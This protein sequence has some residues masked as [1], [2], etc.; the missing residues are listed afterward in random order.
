MPLSQTMA[1]LEHGIADGLHLGA[2]VY[3]SLAGTAVADASIGEA[4]VGV[5][6]TPDTIVQWRSSGKPVGAVAIAQLWERG[7]LDLD[8]PVWRFIPEFRAHGKGAVTLR[9]L[10]THTAGL[11]L[12]ATGWTTSSWDEI[13][14]GICA[15]HL[16]AGWVPGLTAGYHAASSWYLLAEI[17]QRIDGRPYSRYVREAIFE[18]L[19]LHDSWIDIPLERLDAYGDRLSEMYNTEDRQ[20]P[21]MG[22]DPMS[23]GHL[24]LPTP[25]G[26]SRPISALQDPARGL[27]TYQ[28][29]GSAR[30][31]TRE[32]GRFYEML[33]ARGRLG[34]VRL[35]SPQTVEA[36]TAR[37]R[38]GMLDRTFQRV[39]DWGLGFI[40][41]SKGYTADPVPY[42]YGPHCSPRT[43]GHSGY[44]SSAGYCD[45]EH[46]LVVAVFTNGIPG[47]AQHQRRFRAIHT[48][49]YEDLGLADASGRRAHTEG[50]SKTR[51]A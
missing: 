7:W 32:L 35:L 3:V 20:S 5:P 49:I 10:L 44:R 17:I 40:L 1:T 14:A 48:A 19:G 42:G 8:D 41:D 24:E 16:E 27:F 46:G 45:P 37:H 36:L 23:H 2:Q 34:D 38:T 25:G 39:V 50:A 9:H 47:E 12:V 22:P 21:P 51:G 33:Q 26:T 29:G 31:P 11:R 6:M 28:P 4:R 43:F 15:S 30:G 13:I 18:P